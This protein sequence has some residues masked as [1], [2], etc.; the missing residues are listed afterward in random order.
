MAREFLI[1]VVPLTLLIGFT[2]GT[3]L[4]GLA[5]PTEAA[6]C[7]AVGATLLAAAYGKL[8]KKAL[9]NAAMSAR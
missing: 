3:I 1:G 2:L 8:S 7:G 4:A 6:S 9:K 5:T